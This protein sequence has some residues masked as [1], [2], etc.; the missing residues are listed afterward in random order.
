LKA[1]TRVADKTVPVLEKA[2]AIDTSKVGSKSSNKAETNLKA[3]QA[4]LGDAKPDSTTAITAADATQ[5]ESRTA[6]P[7]EL[8]SKLAEG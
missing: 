2:V 6:T 7:L 8:T 3:L 4:K 1:D 5:A